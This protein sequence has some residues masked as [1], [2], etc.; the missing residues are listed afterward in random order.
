MIRNG[1]RYILKK[2]REAKEYESELP[3]MKKILFWGGVSMG[4]FFVVGI[5]FFFV[6]SA[7]LPSV[8]EIGNRQ[9][10]E[11]TKIFDR[12][13]AILLFEI[14][15]EERRTTIPDSQI[16]QH[17]KDATIAIED[18][19]FY[20]E[21]AFDWKGILRA[22]YI[23][24]TRG[25][26][27]Q[28]GSTITQQLAKKAF[29]TDARTPIRKM[30]EF[31]LAIRLDKVYTKD[32][33]LTL[34]LNQIP[35]SANTYGV[36]SAAQTLFGKHA[37][38]LTLAQS[39]LLAALP[40]A[41][42]YYSPYG[43]HVKELMARKDFVLKRMVDLGYI[44]PSQMAA[45]K[46]ENLAF[47]DRKSRGIKAPHF[48]SYVQDYLSQ[49]YGDDYIRTAGLKVTTTLD[50]ELE[51]IAE[52]AV[53][54]GVKRNTELY[55]GRNGALVALDPKTG[56]ILAMV[57]SANYFDRA[58]EGNFNVAAQG[59]RQPG[60]TFKPF[61]YLTAFQKGL[62]PDTIVWDVQTE[63]DTTNDP[64]NSYMPNNN[65]L[66]FV[67]PIKLKEALATSRNIPGVKALY[68]AGVKNTINNAK[69]FGI[70]TLN[71]PNRYGLS[72]VLG[73]GE[74]TLLEL[75]A[76][77]GV[78][79]TEGYKNQ[80]AAILKIE[81][82]DG[83]ILEEFE[84]RPEE[85][86]DSQ[87]PRLINDILS[88]VSLRQ[89]LYQSSL[90]LTQV[91]GYQIA[92]KTG[93]TNDYVDA[94]TM[95]YTPNLVVGVWAGNNRREPLKS[96]GGSVLAALPIWHEFVSKA[97]STNKFEAETFTSPE[98][99][100]SDNPTIRGELVTD[101]NGNYHDVLHYLDRYNDSQYK[102]WEDGVKTWLASNSLNPN[103][104]IASANP[105]IGFGTASTVS[106]IVYQPAQSSVQVDIV[107]PKNGEM[108]ASNV[109]MI[110]ANISATGGT[111]PFI[112]RVEV[113]LN[114]ALID[115][116]EGNLG[117]SF[118]YFSQYMPTML[119]PQNLL[120]VKA[121]DSTGASAQRDIIFFT[122]H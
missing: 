12:T 95:G 80:P 16:P 41:P 93:T 121:I 73:G 113:Y 66:E 102:N 15:G 40:K 119:N 36:E 78:F 104:Y 69:K 2:V 82:K 90:R 87:Y 88:D 18:A 89:G 4:S 109:V 29:L 48:V 11:S 32:Q 62:T 70:T 24:I 30:K 57:G 79:A 31:L 103:K 64:A 54:N 108:T 37:K 39:A 7:S 44:T 23:N 43:S 71:D 35:Y 67:G 8:E 17:L 118:G 22:T 26:L 114:N 45:A 50:W 112:A 38:D 49:K 76:A 75:A 13:G 85:V 91:P 96:R 100:N 21:P 74:V 65:D 120:T 9:V 97:L 116:R 27:L 25:R 47:A 55:E 94:W 33:I 99:V 56:Q 72:L 34:Y 105:A 53:A 77:Y 84:P 111:N 92:V 68:I 98:P 51:Q 58:N 106:A 83:N 14:H 28:G 117:P 59:L 101:V 19:S 42:S 110:N 1:I 81:D 5:S 63:F 46:Q 61:A 3:M 122:Q 60:S 10:I 6:I 52:K 115:V 20:S 107:S 86:V